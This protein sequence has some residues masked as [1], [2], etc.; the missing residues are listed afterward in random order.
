MINVGFHITMRR[1]IVKD[2]KKEKKKKRKLSHFLNGEGVL[3]DFEI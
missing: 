1:K 3:M 2:S